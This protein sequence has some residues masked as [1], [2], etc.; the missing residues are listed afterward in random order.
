MSM[1]DEAPEPAEPN[2]APLLVGIET[3]SAMLA[4]SERQIRSMLSGG[5]FPA[6]VELDA[7]ITRWRVADIQQWVADL[8]AK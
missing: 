1:I 2:V 5:R 8:D 4:I 7:R 6:P 3:V